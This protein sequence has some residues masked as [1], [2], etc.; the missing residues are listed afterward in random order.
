MKSN[1]DGR[2]YFSGVAWKL[3]GIQHSG[4][5]GKF[6][7][8]ARNGEWKCSGKWFWASLWWHHEATLARRSQ[9]SWRDVDCY[10]WVEVGGCWACGCSICKHQC[11][12]LVA[13]C[14]REP[15]IKIVCYLH[16]TLGLKWIFHQKEWKCGDKCIHPQAIRVLV[17]FFIRNYLENC[18]NT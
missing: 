1:D 13:S 5:G 11:L 10:R 3:S 12:E 8:P 6:I 2:D 15:V 17:C 7:P 4:W 16:I 18:S 14:N 9:T